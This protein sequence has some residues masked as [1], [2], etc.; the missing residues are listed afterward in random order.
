[1]SSGQL[2][3]ENS[4]KRRWACITEVEREKRRTTSRNHYHKN[5]DEIN[6]KRRQR[7][8]A[9]KRYCN[10]NTYTLLDYYNKLTKIQD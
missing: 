2:A 7:Y 8:A 6:K 5:V 9:T 3:S 4:I 1:M 10:S